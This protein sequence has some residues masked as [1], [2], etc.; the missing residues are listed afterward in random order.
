[1]ALPSSDIYADLYSKMHFMFLILPKFCNFYDLK[2]IEKFNTCEKCRIISYNKTI[3]IL[4]VLSLPV[5]LVNCS[6][7][8]L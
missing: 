5:L 3:R 2:K 1:M 8:K 7:L 6:E 4:N